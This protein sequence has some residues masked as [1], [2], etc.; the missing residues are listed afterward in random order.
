MPVTAAPDRHWLICETLL[1]AH[2]AGSL[3]EA[4]GLITAATVEGSLG[5]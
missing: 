5:L 2:L 1:K 4:R 3:P